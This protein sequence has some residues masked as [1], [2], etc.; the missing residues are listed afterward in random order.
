[1][2]PLKSSQLELDTEAVLSGL[3][4]TTHDQIKLEHL[5]MEVFSLTLDI[6]TN[7]ISNLTAKDSL[8]DS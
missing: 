1:M 3:H 7:S 6:S 4:N 2:F 5:K 8:E